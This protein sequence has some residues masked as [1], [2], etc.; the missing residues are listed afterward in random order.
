MSVATSTL[1]QVLLK[2]YELLAER[3]A[4]LVAELEQ[5]RS[6]RKAMEQELEMTEDLLVRY[7]SAAPGETDPVP[8][9]VNHLDA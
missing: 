2:Q 8:H 7:E 9:H 1:P 3:Y 5:E 6:L 4:N